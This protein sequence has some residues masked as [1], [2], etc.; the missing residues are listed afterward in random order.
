MRIPR[1]RQE[2]RL[3]GPRW[4]RIAVSGEKGV[5]GEGVPVVIII[6]DAPGRLEM[7]RASGSAGTRRF[8]KAGGWKNEVKDK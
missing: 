1:P 4:S 2:A 5:N 6:E 8:A 7:C 3:C